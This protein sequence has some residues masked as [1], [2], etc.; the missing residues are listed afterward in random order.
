MSGILALIVSFE[1]SVNVAP[2]E[3]WSLLSLRQR[4]SD[5]GFLGQKR[6]TVG[7]P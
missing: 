1:S 3:L 2:M 4:K 7:R 5:I 6:S